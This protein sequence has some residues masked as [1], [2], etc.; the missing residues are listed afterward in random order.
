MKLKFPALA[1]ARAGK[2]NKAK[3]DVG[4][5]EKVCE[6]GSAWQGGLI[7]S[8]VE[9]AIN[10]RIRSPR[11]L[12]IDD[13]G[14]KIG[15]MMT[16]DAIALAREKGL[17]LVEVAPLADPPVARVLDYGKYLYTQQKRSRD[18]K[19]KQVQQQVKEI[20]LRTKT[21]E[22]DLQTKLKKAKEFL[23]KGDRVKVH[24]MYRG[25]EMAHPELGRQML[26]KVIAELEAF[27]TP[28]S[29]GEMQGRNLITYILPNPKPV[30]P[31]KKSK[32]G[33]SENSASPEEGA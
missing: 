7:I 13:T 3:E 31:G 17:D 6:H 1:G 19:K 10:E 8:T 30:A 15:V 20:K 9:L 26:K 14:A 32:D 12:V 23:E 29:E 22:H 11:V 33:E 27:G 18:A 16:R 21:E 28:Q 2:S 25:R 4:P 24:V 5:D